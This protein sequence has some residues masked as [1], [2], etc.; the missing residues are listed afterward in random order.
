MLNGYQ[1]KG[2]GLLLQDTAAMLQNRLKSSDTASMLASYQSRL[3][4]NRDAINLETTRATAAEL[5]KINY[6]DSSAMLNGY[7]RKGT[8][9]LLQDTAAAFGVRPLN[10]RFT[11][12]IATL[13]TLANSRASL[14]D[15]TTILVG[16]WLPNRNADSAAALQSRIQTKSPLEGSSSITTVGTLTSGSIPYALLTGTP[17]IPSNANFVDLTSTQTIGGSKTFSTDVNVRGLTIGQGGGGVNSNTASGRSALGTN[18]T[19]SNNTANG[20]FALSQNT[21]GSD[22]TANGFFALSQNTTG[23]GNTANGNFALNSNTTGGYNTANGSNALNLNTSGYNNTANG[24]SALY[25]NTTGSNNTA[26]GS[27]ALSSNTTGSQNTANG[28]QALGSNTTGNGNT[29]NGFQALNL[30]TTGSYNTANG[31]GALSYSVSGDNNT[32]VG[33]GAGSFIADGITI[34]SLINNSVFI[35]SQS[36]ALADNQTNQIVI[37]YNAIGNGSNTVTLGNSD[38]TNV[39]TSGTLTAGAVTYPKAHGSA[40]QVLVTAGSGTLA[41]T[42]L[43][44]STTSTSA[45]FLPTIVIGRQQWMRENL[46]VLTYRN[47]DIIPQVTDPTA[48]AGLTTGAWCYYNNDPET[49]AIYGKLY[50]WYAVNDPRGLAPTGWHIPTDEEWTTLGTLLDISSAGGKMKTTGITRW[51]TPNTSATNESGYSGLPG[52]ARA[53]NGTFVAIGTSGYWWSA[54]QLS[55]IGAWYRNLNY[56]NGNLNRTS[57]PKSVGCSVRCIRD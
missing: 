33:S 28:L 2:T 30:N 23:T 22:N 25:Q 37:G 35:G 34:N 32:V 38:I 57:S 8:G 54:T 36:K 51:T 7:Q 18:T 39:N 31:T 50:N 44:A 47:G 52:G 29:A 55:A 46:D 10:N 12:S 3:N 15:S 48:W 20:F 9:L 27:S 4:A 16:R 45:V 6:T 41:W 5:L 14:S 11:D 19:G 26:N 56:A 53:T 43:T 17:S 21:T 42:T 1:R 49:G 24:N 40:G 13:R